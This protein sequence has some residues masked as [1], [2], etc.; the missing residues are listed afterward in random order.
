[1]QV[2]DL[3]TSSAEALPGDLGETRLR[4]DPTRAGG[5]LPDGQTAATFDS[6]SDWLV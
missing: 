5:N 1:L 4:T 6:G 2:D 3:H